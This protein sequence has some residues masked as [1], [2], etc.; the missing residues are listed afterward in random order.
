M[1]ETTTC[2][3]C[4]ATESNTAVASDRDST[5]VCD[6]IRSLTISAAPEVMGKTTFLSEACTQVDVLGKH[7]VPSSIHSSQTDLQDIR[8]YFARPRLIGLGSIPVGTRAPFDFEQ[9]TATTLFSILY[10][11]GL[12]R[13]NGA[14]GVKFS[15]VFTLQVAATPFHQGLLAL[16]FQYDTLAVNTDSF[17]RSDNS[18]TATNIPHVRLDLSVDTMAVL[19]VPFLALEEFMSIRDALAGFKYGVAAL[20]TILPVAAVVGISPPT[21]KLLVH[22][23]DMELVSVYPSVTENIVLQAGRTLGIEQ[24][25]KLSDGVKESSKL[26]A[27]VARNIPMLSSI[28]GPTS[29]F[30]GATSGALRAFGYSKPQIQDSPIR[31]LRGQTAGEQN[32]DLPSATQV[33]GPMASNHLAV[34]PTFG[35]TDVDEMALAFVCGQ[36]SQI[37]VGAFST[38]LVHGETLYATNVSPSSMWFR[39]GASAPYCNITAPVTSIGATNGF[40]PSSVFFWASMFRLWRSSFTFRVTFAKTKMHGGRVLMTFVPDVQYWPFG[41]GSATAKAPGTYIGTQPNGYST[42]FDLRDGNVFE[43]EVPYV[44]PVPYMDF[45]SN[46]GG[47]TM[48]VMDALQAPSVVSSSIPFLIEVKANADVEFAVPGGPAY[49][50]HVRATIR[51]QSG[52]VLSVIQS[53]ASQ[54]T[55]GEKIT[56]V[57]QLLMMPK[58]NESNFLAA[59]TSY[60]LAVMP[61][62]YHRIPV[63]TAPFPDANVLT[64][65]FSYGGNAATCYAFVRGGTDIHIY[66]VNADNLLIEAS[67]TAPD[68][69]LY[70][71]AASV[72]NSSSSSLPRVMAGLG[73]PLHVKYPAYH[74]TVRVSSYVFNRI[75]WACSFASALR[76]FVW[77]AA[78]WPGYVAVPQ[79]RLA[80]GLAAQVNVK[81]CRCAGDDA[82]LS[83]YMGPPP[84]ALPPATATGIYDPDYVNGTA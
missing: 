1:F 78:T 10:P 45:A 22:L 72:R 62:F 33:V 64:E 48:T 44:A 61:W 14:Y 76:N 71:T 29:W 60:T 36:Y 73:T 49:S 75:Q 11:D 69:G 54:L 53:D 23:E 57:K 8:T 17:L 83:M 80:N 18:N 21:Y 9:I 26:A 68:Y 74:S 20:N 15:L 40:Q 27:F 42:L 19:K 52:R 66:P 63:V 31:V 43:F 3:I 82:A 32:V 51:E 56:S 2:I 24:E 30:L 47:L 12:F 28:A 5:E 38:A 67:Y 65:G 59:A 35:G 58:W 25:Y 7:H 46:I 13:L 34:S 70:I 55:V 84:L 41:T 81:T 39:A 4:L 16:S 79:L 50:A 6:E 37:C 77:P